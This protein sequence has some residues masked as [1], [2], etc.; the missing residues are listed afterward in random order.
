MGPH[1]KN[2]GKENAVICILNH[3]VPGLAYRL[4]CMRI[5]TMGL[6]QESSTLK[7]RA[8]TYVEPDERFSKHTTLVLSSCGEKYLN[9]RKQ[10]TEKL[11]Q[12]FKEAFASPN[13]LTN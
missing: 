4:Q 7:I 12:E 10:A 5:T 3:S 1:T 8:E 11:Y 6:F 13:L 9:G 2:T